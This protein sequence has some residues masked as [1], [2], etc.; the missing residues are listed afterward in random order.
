MSPCLMSLGRMPGM[1]QLDGG[2]LLVGLPLRE[3]HELELHAPRAEEVLPALPGRG[4]A[5]R[6][7]AGQQPH[8]LRAQVADGLIHVVDVEGDVVAAQVAVAR[9]RALVRQGLVLE[10]LE[11]EAEAA[12]VEADLPH[13]R[14]GVD[15]EV[16]EHP[17]VV[18]AHL[19]QRVDVVAA[20]HAGEEGMGLLHI[21]DGD[22]D[23]DAASQSGNAWG[24]GS[25]S[26]EYVSN[27]YA[28]TAH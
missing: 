14:A 19:G 25:S 7:G 20:Q 18:A 1:P 4:V 9:L 22:A 12:A 2:V 15:V 23:V 13:G 5:A 17:V 6:D 28:P 16:L 24:H 10:D 3:A 26:T 8:A 21:G 11:V 27:I